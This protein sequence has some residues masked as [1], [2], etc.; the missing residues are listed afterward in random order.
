MIKFTVNI[1]NEII[2]VLR[3]VPAIL[4]ILL[5]MSIGR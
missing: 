2:D 1:T 4:T 5:D 3:E